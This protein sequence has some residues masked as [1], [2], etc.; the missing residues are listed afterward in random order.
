M[1][2]NP[3]QGEV[4]FVKACQDFF[5]QEPLGKKVSMDEFKA[6]SREDKVELREELIKQGYN[7]S[8]LAAPVVVG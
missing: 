5:T 8:E 1:I 4:S 6:L 2:P 7:V 3:L